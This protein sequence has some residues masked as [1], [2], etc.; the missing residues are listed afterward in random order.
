MDKPSWDELFIAEAVLDSSRGTCNRLL[1]ACVLAV[2]NKKVAS[3]YNGAVSKLENCDD[4]DHKM[5]EGHC[6]RTLHGEVNAVSNAVSPLNGATAYVVAT[7]CVNCV[8]LLLQE[9]IKRIVYVGHYDN[10]PGSDF[11]HEI[12]QKKGIS[13]EQWTDN[14]EEVAAIFKK[15]FIRLQGPGGIFKEVDLESALFGEKPAKIKATMLEGKLIIFEGIDK[16]GKTTQLQRLAGYLLGKGYEVVECKEPPFADPKLGIPDIRQEIMD[17]RKARPDLSGTALAEAEQKLF[18]N[19]RGILY[20]K[21][22]IPARQAGKIVVCDRGPDST[23]PYQ[24]YGRGMNLDKIRAANKIATRGL[25]AD[26]T[27]LFD[28]EPSVAMRRITKE[29]QVNRFE[30]EPPEFWER[31]KMGYILEMARDA[32]LKVKHWQTIWA[33]DEKNIITK[34]VIEAVRERLGL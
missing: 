32:E 25:N 17:L 4:V 22:I 13:L 28:I 14:P 6:I 15:I 20:D 1:T 31:V 16:C 24:G 5:V 7:P 34:K 30:K 29:D 21:V 27:L 33:D 23:P 12:C 10:G 9:K 19:I 8:K 11:I 18:A 3:G 26:L 2:D